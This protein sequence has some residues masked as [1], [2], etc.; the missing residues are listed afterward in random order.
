MAHDVIKRVGE[1]AYRYRVETYRDPVTK[2]V[3]SRWTYAGVVTAA[4]D[5]PAPK[6]R[7]PRRTRE[8]LVD[9][10]EQLCERGSASSFSAAAIAAEAGL[11]SGTFYRYFSD[12]RAILIAALERVRDELERG[13]PSFGPP[14]GSRDEERARI[15]A[16]V[17]ELCRFVPRRAGVVRAWLEA[18]EADPQLRERRVER[19]RER[20]LALGNYLEALGERGIV[21]N[22][23]P[24]SLS[25]ALV[26]LVDA[27]FRE[28]VSVPSGGDPALEAGIVETFDRSIFGVDPTPSRASPSTDSAIGSRAV[29][30]VK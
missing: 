15:R 22:I 24:L 20:I 28:S 9:A 7:A 2:R 26:T 30:T 6:R 18:L 4:L 13:S 10:F 3:R 1:R 25:T 11:A 21:V 17:T 16:W 19:R 29:P 14:Y 23:R 27:M 12:K 5:G 8:R